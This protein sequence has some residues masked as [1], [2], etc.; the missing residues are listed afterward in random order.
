MTVTRPSSLSRLR[1]RAGV[2]ARA[3]RANSP[4]ADAR[5]TAVLNANGFQV[6]RFSDRE[7]LTEMDGALTAILSRLHSL[8]HPH[9]NPLPPA[10]EGVIQESR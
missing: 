1:Q 5:R 3:L 4:D 7:V 9:P 8:H 10:G 2:R 6:L